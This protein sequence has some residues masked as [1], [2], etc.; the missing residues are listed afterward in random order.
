MCLKI[1]QTKIGPRHH[2]PHLF[3]VPIPANE[4][5]VAVAVA[6]AASVAAAVAAVGRQAVPRKSIL[7]NLRIIWINHKNQA[8]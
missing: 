5:A 1:V 7:Q 6:V 3:D 4:I 8:Q 2:H